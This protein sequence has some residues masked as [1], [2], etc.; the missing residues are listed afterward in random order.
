M[1]KRLRI[2]AL[3]ILASL[4]V[5]DF[6][7]TKMALAMGWSELNPLVSHA[8]LWQ[9]KLLALGICGLLVWRASRERTLWIAGFLYGGIVVWNLSLLAR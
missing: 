2:I 9:A 5:V 8:G 3:L 6:L 4:Q 7:S 1:T